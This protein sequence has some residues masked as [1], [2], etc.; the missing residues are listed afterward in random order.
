MIDTI[1][2]NCVI[3]VICHVDVT[4]TFLHPKFLDKHEIMYTILVFTTFQITQLFEL[5]N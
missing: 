1:S 5:L 3:P 2:Q 4:K